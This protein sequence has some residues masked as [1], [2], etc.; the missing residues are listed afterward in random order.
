MGLYFKRAVVVI[1]YL[2]DGC[3]FY[4]QLNSSVGGW[5]RPAGLNLSRTFLSRT[6]NYEIRFPA[7]QRNL[8]SAR[9]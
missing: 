1:Y 6:P 7:A 5:G 2:F 3:R 8:A 4:G 9:N